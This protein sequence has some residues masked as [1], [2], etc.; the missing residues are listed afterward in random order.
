M[1]KSL[2]ASRRRRNGITMAL[3]YAATGFGLSW[4]VLILAVLL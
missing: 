3:A 1:D 2:Y 4:L